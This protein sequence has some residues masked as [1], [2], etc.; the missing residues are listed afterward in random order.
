MLEPCIVPLVPLRWHRPA[1]GWAFAEYRPALG[2]QLFLGPKA[3]IPLVAGGKQ[4]HLLLRHALSV[5]YRGTPPHA[6][7]FARSGLGQ[8]LIEDAG[9][10]PV[11][12][13][14]LGATDAMIAVALAD[15]HAIGVDVET[16]PRVALNASHRDNWLS[17]GERAAVNGLTGPQLV[18]ELACR[19]TLKEAIGKAAGVGLALP[20]ASLTIARSHSGPVAIAM[21]QSA[22]LVAQRS[23]KLFG[24]GDLIVGLAHG[25]ATGNSPAIGHASERQQPD[26]RDDPPADQAAA[27]HHHCP[28]PL[29]HLLHGRLVHAEARH[30]LGGHHQP[31]R[32]SARGRFR[33]LA[34]P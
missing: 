4:S 20:L 30:V 25:P 13:F 22:S 9:D 14:S 3:A 28:D 27:D 32:N 15:A 12:R 2:I 7:R 5:R 11:P 17:P 1:G 23:L 16:R 26:R 10:A 18:A 29:R 19:W 6:W 33:V 34:H 8:L 31:P 24:T 21:G